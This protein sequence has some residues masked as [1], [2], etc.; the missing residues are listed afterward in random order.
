M[1]SEKPDGERGPAQ[2]TLGYSISDYKRLI[3]ELEGNSLTEAKPG[4][5]EKRGED[6]FKRYGDPRSGAVQS[7]Q[8]SEVTSIFEMLNRPQEDGVDLQFYPV[9]A[10]AT[11]SK[12]VEGVNLF[13]EWL[14][15]DD[16]KPIGLENEPILYISDKCRNLCEC[17]KLWTGAGGEKGAAKDPVD[18]CRYAAVSDIEHYPAGALEVTGGMG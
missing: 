5:P 12:I 7:V 18:L 1:P 11:R 10:D 6:I 2:E 4:E 14:E 3:W 15:Y 17:L 8:E 13:N 9:Q 16:E